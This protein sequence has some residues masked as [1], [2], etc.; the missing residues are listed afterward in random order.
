MPLRT[1]CSPVSLYRL[2]GGYEFAEYLVSLSSEDVRL[3]QPVMVGD[4]SCKLY[5]GLLRSE[6]P[7]WS[8]HVESL[9][10]LPVDLPGDHPFAVLLAPVEQWMYAL[11]WGGGHLLIDDELVDQGFGL[12]FGIRRLDSS[13]L[14]LVASSA[15]DATARATQTSF[16]GGSDLGGFHLEPYGEMV[17]RLAGSADL[18]GL[19]YGRETGRAYRIQVGNALRAPLAREPQALLTDL[20]AIGTV[21]DEPDDHST[22]RFIAQTRPVPKHHPKLPELERRLALALGGDDTVGVLG[23]A[24]PKEAVDDAN[25]AGSFKVLRL[26]PGPYAVDTDI[27]LSALTD[28]FA[29]IAVASRLEDL[30]AAR[31]VA[32][33][34]EGGTEQIGSLISLRKWIAFETVVDH[35]RYGYHQGK[36]FRIG[37]GFVDQIRGHVAELLTRKSALSF[38]HWTPTGERQDEHHYCEQV[39]KQPGYLCLDQNFAHTPFHPRFELCDV[40]GPAGELVHVKWLG[41]ATAASHLYT[42]ASVSAEALRDEPEASTQLNAK[43]AELDPGRS[44][45]EPS[46]VVL[47]IAGRRWDVDQLFTLSQLSLLRL[48]RTLRHLRMKLEFAEIP[49]TPKLQAKRDRDNS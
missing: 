47:A 10:G 26:G 49:F 29:E 40:V 1:S 5:A 6:R 42:Q 13:R 34:D 45:V 28:R 19:T 25:N 24:W 44:P 31:M 18:T 8:T 14:G 35:V 20:Q 12:M 27:E 41:K 9:T 21:V 22:L 43:I 48:D 46:T 33:A 39:A 16:P 4:I 32:C 38:P 30:R 36:W 15:L 7:A 11:T 3:D 2:D 23:L 37:E 17:N